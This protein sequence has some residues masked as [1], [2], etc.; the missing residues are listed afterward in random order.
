MAKKQTLPEYETD[1]IVELIRQRIH[2][3]LDRKMLY[4][5]LVDG[6]TFEEILDKVFDNEK[7][8]TVK[9]VRN[10]IHKG[11]KELFRHLPG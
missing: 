3:K 6:D 11:E 5:R 4:W 8:R 1:Q 10:R 7:I 9:T 2:D